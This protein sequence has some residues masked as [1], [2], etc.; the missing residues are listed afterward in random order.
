MLPMCV[1]T[2]KTNCVEN[3]QTVKVYLTS[4][5][6]LFLRFIIWCWSP[7]RIKYILVSGRASSVKFSAKY[8]H[9]SESAKTTV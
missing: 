2:G 4:T 1:F 3:F 7:A 9:K 8:N 6:F 5:V